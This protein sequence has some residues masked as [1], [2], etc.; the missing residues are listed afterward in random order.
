MGNATYAAKAD[1]EP[2]G[3]S[4]ILRTAHGE[5]RPKTRADIGLD[6]EKIVPLCSRE[7]TAGNCILNAEERT[8]LVGDLRLQIG[9]A[10]TD[11]QKALTETKVELLLQK[12]SG[13]GLVGELLFM[14][15]AALL[16]EGVA[17]VAA[18]IGSILAG[19]S[20]NLIDR[21]A[22][23][24]INM[25]VLAASHTKAIESIV[26]NSVSAAKTP[27]R[28][29]YGG[30]SPEVEQKL[31]FVDA[32]ADDT[33]D[34][35]RSIAADALKNGD[36]V[37]LALL[38]ATF[39]QARPSSFKKY[40]DDLISRFTATE[41][42]SL[43]TINFMGTYGGTR[44]VVRIRSGGK[45]RYAMIEFRESVTKADS[46]HEKWSQ[47]GG[48]RFLRWIDS[49]LEAVSTTTQLDTLGTMRTLGAD[50]PVIAD[51]PE[52]RAWREETAR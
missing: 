30:Y 23:E 33:G 46:H 11:F 39:K 18:D 3:L 2:D 4:A 25:E 44:E 20:A 19:Y 48:Q 32:L 38:T 42:N 37:T 45:T 26:K 36:D 47:Q 49:D 5:T 27:L 50:H 8:Y 40:I 21:A 28:S 9:M 22:D 16:T 14:A 35:F 52:I 31:A 34:L 41:L 15:A 51:L 1:E 29:K 6:R 13:W 24:A 7:K 12:S 10:Y 17:L 43:G